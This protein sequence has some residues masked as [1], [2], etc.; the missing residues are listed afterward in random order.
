MTR[1]IRLA[2]IL[3]LLAC[4][5]V[6]VMTVTGFSRVPWPVWAIFGVLAVL[7]ISDWWSRR[8]PQ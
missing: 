7:F 8:Q 1:N 4:G 6:L 5:L 3:G 2:I